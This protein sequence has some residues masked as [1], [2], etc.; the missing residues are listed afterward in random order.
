MKQLQLGFWWIH[1]LPRYWRWRKGWPLPP[2]M[3]CYFL[4]VLWHLHALVF[5][6]H[7][8]ITSCSEMFPRV[9]YT[10]LHQIYIFK[11]KSCFSLCLTDDV[12]LDLREETCCT[13][14]ACFFL[15]FFYIGNRICYWF[16]I[17]EVIRVFLS[18]P[19]SYLGHGIRTVLKDTHR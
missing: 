18:P 3:R 19:Q 4:V 8:K 6:T 15:V 2:R 16:L 12:A 17:C 7:P 1:S 9:P 5:E 13:S 11:H 10:W 14:L